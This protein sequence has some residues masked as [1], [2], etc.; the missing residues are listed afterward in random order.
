MTSI[1]DAVGTFDDD[2]AATSILVNPD[3]PEVNSQTDPGSST[4]RPLR[5]AE[6]EAMHRLS[7]DWLPRFKERLD[8]LEEK[9][10][11][12]SSTADIMQSE[13]PVAR[14]DVSAKSAEV[15]LV[16]GKP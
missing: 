1:M 3:D 9:L 12:I 4:Q 6:V 7:L 8:V 16:F 14:S 11:N 2:D 15:R 5:P 13:V 10:A